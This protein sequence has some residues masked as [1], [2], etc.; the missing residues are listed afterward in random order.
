VRHRDESSVIVRRE[1][2]TTGVEASTASEVELK[3]IS[4]VHI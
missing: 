2:T 4:R 3:Y 1:V